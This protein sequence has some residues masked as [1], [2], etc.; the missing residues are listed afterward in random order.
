MSLQE[1]GTLDTGRTPMKMEAETGGV[2]PRAEGCQASPAAAESWT[3]TQADPSL[4]PQK[5]PDLAHT[6][7]LDFW[8][9]EM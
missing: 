3:E 5:G 6:L 1:Q 4:E 9:L 7:V 2:H 8:P